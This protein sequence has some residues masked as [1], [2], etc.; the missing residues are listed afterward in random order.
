MCLE[1]LS[2]GWLV[3]GSGDLTLIL[4]PLDE[5]KEHLSVFN[6]HA[7]GIR[8]LKLLPNGSFASGSDDSKIKIWTGDNLACPVPQCIK[9]LTGHGGSVY[10]L[11]LTVTGNLLI[12]CSFDSSIRV[13]DWNEGVCV[14]QL[15]GHE[16]S[17]YCIKLKKT[18]GELLSA[19]KDDCVK[20]WNLA[21][22]ECVRSIQANFSI[23]NLE[24]SV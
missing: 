9:S 19:S 13:W 6:A 12:S 2:D 7:R 20:V 23:W 8:C 15:N 14:R 11:E 22:G 17:V 18:T 16:D 10:S 4:W 3:S 21:S 24:V 5:N 1:E